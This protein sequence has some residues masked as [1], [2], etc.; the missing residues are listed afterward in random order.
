MKTS[1][2]I[3]SLAEALS[4]AQGEMTGA[5]KSLVNSF[6]KS[7]Y[8]DLSSVVEAISG[9]FANHGL[10]FVQAPGIGES[11]MITV[12]TRLMH[13]SGQ[14]IEGTVTLPPTK[15][16]A[17]GYGSAITYGRRYGLQSIA[18]VPS[19]DD[20]A[21]AAVQHT[22]KPSLTPSNKAVWAKAKA[23]LAEH[24]SLGNVLKAFDMSAEHQAAILTE[25]KQA[26][27]VAQ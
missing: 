22:A 18:G 15:N 16:D 19:V 14:W 26:D 3:E 24:G 2:N 4:K 21:Q 7:K 27:E 17:Q 13:S 12:T 25:V 10:S 9:P 11:G 23:S 5:K 6:F 1:E 8:S 20:D